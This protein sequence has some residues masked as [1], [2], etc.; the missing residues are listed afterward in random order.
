[1]RNKIFSTD[2]NSSVTTL[3]RN[4]ISTSTSRYNTQFYKKYET[5]CIS[6]PIFQLY[7]SVE[8]IH[9]WV[10]IYILVTHNILEGKASKS[11]N[12]KIDHIEDGKHHQAENIL[13]N[14]K[15]NIVNRYY[16][17]TNWKTNHY[18]MKEEKSDLPLKIIRYL[19]V[20]GKWL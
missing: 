7:I 17:R 14:I 9:L 10:Y 16:T 19:L 4:C 15:S 12:N 5:L 18:E 3:F 2:Q 11:N 20:H 8:Q 1:M 6:Q 13:Q